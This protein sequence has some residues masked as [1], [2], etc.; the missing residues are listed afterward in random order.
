MPEL[1]FFVAYCIKLYMWVFIID[2]ILNWLVSLNVINTSSH[3]VYLIGTAL[4]RLT[5]P[6]LQPIRRRMPNL[7]GIDVSPVIAILGLVF[8]RDVVVLGWLMRILQ[9]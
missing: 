6:V 9:S 2:V 3:F 8:L 1:L 4:R 7:G 5:N